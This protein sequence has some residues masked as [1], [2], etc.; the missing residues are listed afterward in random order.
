[1][2]MHERRK[3]KKATMQTFINFPQYCQ[4]H[5][6]KRSYEENVKNQS[7]VTTRSDYIL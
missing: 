6:H 3:N 2:N 5:R 7:N 1:M 4:Q